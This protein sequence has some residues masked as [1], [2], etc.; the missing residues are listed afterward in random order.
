MK[1]MFLMGLI[2]SGLAISTSAQ[3]TTQPK[4]EKTKVKKTTTLPQKVHNAVSK[5]KKYKGVKVK[6]KVEKPK[7]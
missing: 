5:N 2:L 1:K 7:Q 3:T 6:H 4:D